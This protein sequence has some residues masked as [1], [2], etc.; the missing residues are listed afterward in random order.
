MLKPESTQITKDKEIH[1]FSHGIKPVADSRK[2]LPPYR[3]G[4][5]IQG[6]QLMKEDQYINE[7]KDKGK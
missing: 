3:E 2:E 5:R 7:E 4:Q 6:G 1:F